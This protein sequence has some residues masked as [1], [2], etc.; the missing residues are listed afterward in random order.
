MLEFSILAI[1]ATCIAGMMTRAQSRKRKREAL[2]PVW[3]RENGK[4]QI[5]KW[6]EGFLAKLKRTST[7]T[8]KCRL[9]LAVERMQFERDVY[10]AWWKYVQFGEEKVEIIAYDNDSLQKIKI[11]EFQK[12]L[13]KSNASLKNQLIGHSEIKEEKGEW[14]IPAELKTKIIS[15]GGEALVFSEKFGFFETAVRVQ[16]FDPFLFTNNFGLDLLTWKINFEK[17]YEKAVNK[18]QSEKQNQMPKHKN[19]IKN[20]VNIELFHKKDLKQEDCIGWITIMEKADEDLR[21]VLKDE[22]IGIEQRK[23]IAEGILDGI[24]YL[25]NIGIVH[26]DKKMENVLLMN[27]FPKIIDFG[28]IREFTGRM[29]YREMGYARKGSKFRIITA[30]SSATPGFAAQAQITIGDGYKTINLFYFLF[31]DWKSS[32]NLLYKPIDEKERKKIDK[33]VKNC[34]AS[35]IHKIKERNISI[36][37]EITSIISIPSSSSHFC[38]DDPN[39]TKSVQVSS[40][41]QNATKCVI[42]D[43]ENLTKNVLDQKSSNLCVPIS[44]ATLLRFAIKNDLGLDEGNYYSAEKI[45]S[46]LTLIV[47]PRSMAGLNLNPNKEETEF[48]LNQIELLLER[49]CKK[50]YLMETGWEIIRQLYWKE[51]RQPKESTCKFEKI[52]LHKNFV[53]SRPLTVTGAI[54][55][56]YKRIDGID[57]PE[58]L[59]FHQMTLDRIENGEY[60]LQNNQFTD[61]SSTVIRIKQRYPHYAAEPFVSNLEN[62]TGDNIFIDGNIKIELI[63]EQYYMTRNRWFLLPYAYSLKLTEV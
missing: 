18:E 33:I 31:C 16:I 44:V 35:S 60:V 26:F 27:G 47:Y 61:Q 28:L 45:L 57:Y 46:T 51:E 63:N 25:H 39:L 41:K 34:N 1:F 24:V 5:E 6:L 20:F 52:L 48:Q 36:I 17:D 50:T 29:G 3:E 23:K 14:Q 11:T 58:K 19:I 59:F 42:Q 37:R 4:N 21:T 30:L 7:R 43:L 15:E 56:P 10:A 12:Q 22:K 49:L 55:I 40:L 32:W 38:L 62:Q 54:I 2:L 9:I 8:E 13:L 53:C